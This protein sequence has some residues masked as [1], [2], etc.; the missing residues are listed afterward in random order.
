MTFRLAKCLSSPGSTLLYS[1]HS[2]LGLRA[3][4]WKSTVSG[5]VEHGEEKEGATAK[6]FEAIP[7]PTGL[8]FVGT[9]LHAALGGWMDKLHIHTQNRWRQYGSIF[10]ETIG[11]QTLVT[12]ADPDDVAAVLRAE[13]RYPR[14]YAFESFIMAREIMDKKLGV[15][16]ENDETWQHYRTLLN[17]KLLRPQQAAVFTPLMDEAACNLVSYLRR[18]R[19]QGGRVTDF[20][21][22]LF[23]WSM[24]SGSTAMFNQHLGLL[25]E[26]PPQI[27]KDF[28]SSIIKILDTT[29]AMMTIPPKVHKALN[30]KAWRGH[31]EGWQTCFEI[32]KQLIQEIMEREMER[33]EEDEEEIPDL[34]SYLLSVKLSPEEVLANI[35]DVLGAAVDTTSNTMCF[36]LHT[37]ARHPNIQEKLHDEVVRFA[38]D[39]QAPVTQE[40]VHKMPYLR[41]VIKEA[42]RLYPVTYINS[43]VLNH[44][45][46]VCGYKIPAGKTIIICPYVMGRDPKNFDNP[47]EFRPERWY[48]ENSKNLKPFAWL[49]FGFGPRSCVGRRIA[50][51]EMHLA[52][53]RICQNFKLEQKKPEELVGKVRALLVPEK[54]VDL[55]LTDR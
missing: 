5:Q 6:P 17:K 4:R 14:R 3:S 49:P 43:R 25:S 28:I 38:P 40:Q 53:I 46:V 33:K 11:P 1:R 45:A 18:K 52:L 19:D 15:F 20:Q 7:G 22:H 34:V 36:T 26:N 2:S 32:T 13:G 48:R 39:H 29:N 24:E 42:L 51:T 44:D 30:T 31:L 27:A 37:L 16:L 50:E 10:K 35:V 8:P 23:R 55:R 21:G 47:E 9:A 54:S 12:I 41:G